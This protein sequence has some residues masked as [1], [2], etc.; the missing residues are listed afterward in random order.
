MLRRYQY[1]LYIMEVGDFPKRLFIWCP[2]IP[3]DER[4]MTNTTAAHL[5]EA[6][7]FATSMANVAGIRPYFVE[8]SSVIGHVLR[9][10]R[11]ERGGS[12]AQLTTGTLDGAL[13]VWLAR[14][15]FE[16]D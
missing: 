15:G 7:R 6:L 2:E 14:K 4:S 8:L 10:A 5:C 12:A 13:K 9:I 11:D 16:T 3:L 1:T